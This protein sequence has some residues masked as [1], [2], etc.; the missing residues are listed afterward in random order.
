MNKVFVPFV[1]FVPLKLQKF[2]K[3]R[4]GIKYI[5]CQNDGDKGDKGD[6]SYLAL[7][8]AINNNVCKKYNSF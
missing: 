6:N 5:L 7:Q 8:C 3:K 4:H 1:P 2:N